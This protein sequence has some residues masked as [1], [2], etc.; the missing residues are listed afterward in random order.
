[1]PS[2]PLR[3]YFKS[4]ALGQVTRA[5]DHTQ[6]FPPLHASPQSGMVLHKGTLIGPGKMGMSASESGNP[7]NVLNSSRREIAKMS[8]QKRMKH[9]FDCYDELR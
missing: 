9:K 7:F 8:T 6:K 1:L 4:P 3:R 5:S 2:I